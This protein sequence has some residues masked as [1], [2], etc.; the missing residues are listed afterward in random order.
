MRGIRVK[1]FGYVN[2][3]WEF[4]FYYIK[5]KSYNRKQ[6]LDHMIQEINIKE[7]SFTI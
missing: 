4:K 5:A 7:S 3:S 6:K 1:H 2:K